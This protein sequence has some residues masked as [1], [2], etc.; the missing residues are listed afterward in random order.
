MTIVFAVL[1]MVL[2]I[3]AVFT[4]RGG[5][6]N[7]DRSTPSSDNWIPSDILVEECR[8][9]AHDLV[10]ESYTI[11][12]LFITEGLPHYDEP[13]GNEPE[14]GIYTVNSTDYTSLEQI[15]ELVNSTYTQSEAQ[16]ILTNIDGN[17]MAVYKNREVS[18]DAVYTD[19]ASGEA[20]G[21]ERPAYVI[22]TVLGIDAGFVPDADYDKDWSTCSIQVTPVSDDHCDLV[23]YLGGADPES[24][25]PGSVLNTAMTK[26]DGEWRLTEFVY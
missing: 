18:V 4:L 3:V 16:R 15:E 25:D 9:A 12:R 20:T 8:L 24:A 22:K 1:A 11:I 5:K 23:I 14:D 7:G 17:G 26:T 2:A 19:E 13:Y 21:E 10:G 6:D